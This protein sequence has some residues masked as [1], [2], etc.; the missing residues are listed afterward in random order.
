MADWS[1]HEQ[2]LFHWLKFEDGHFFLRFFKKNAFVQV[3]HIILKKII[4]IYKPLVI[5]LKKKFLFISKTRFRWIQK[6]S[7]HQDAPAFG[8]D[9]VYISDPCP[10]YCGGHGDCISGV[11]FCDMG[12][13]GINF[14]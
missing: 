10:N 14:E 11:C 1:M 2:D 9:S 5:S 8:L 7:V 12:M 4:H 3:V 6:S 13:E